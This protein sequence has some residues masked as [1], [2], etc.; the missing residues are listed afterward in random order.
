MAEVPAPAAPVADEEDAAELSH[1]PKWVPTILL[2]I[3]YPDSRKVG[4]GWWLFILA[5][6]GAFFLK[7]ANGDPKLD[8]STWLIC[9]AFASALIGGGTIADA[10]HDLEMAKVNAGVPNAPA[11]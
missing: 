2:H 3:L 11:A 10:K 1:A 6:A 7:K 5:S 8:A 9:A 4:F